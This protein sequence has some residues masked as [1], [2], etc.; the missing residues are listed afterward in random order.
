MATLRLT[1]HLLLWIGFLGGSFVAVRSTEVADDPW[2]TIAWPYFIGA[3]SIGVVGVFLLR[4]TARATAAGTGGR[5]KRL[6]ELTGMVQQLT[7]RLSTYREQWK[8]GD[9]YETHRWIDAHLAELLAEFAD[10]RQVIARTC[11]LRAYGQIMT[12]FAQGERQ[13]NRAWCAS[14]DGYADEVDRCL[15]AAQE[16]F[17]AAAS[18][19]EQL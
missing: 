11:G 8:V 14:S 2:S 16:S 15:F 7:E 6:D 1:G 5:A 12:D 9:V 3:L 10:H 19:L 18:R 17:A 13:I 4:R